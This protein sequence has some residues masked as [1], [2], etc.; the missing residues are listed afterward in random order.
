MSL[1]SQLTSEHRHISSCMDSLDT[2]QAITAS[3]GATNQQQKGFERC[4]Q[5]GATPGGGT[6]AIGQVPS[7]GTQRQVQVF[8]KLKK[9][10][11]KLNFQLQIGQTMKQT[12]YIPPLSILPIPGAT[13][14]IGSV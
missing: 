2:N 6:W 14:T 8:F 11:N 1:P 3:V 13:G 12:N 9:K 7:Q 10:I 4:W 5:K